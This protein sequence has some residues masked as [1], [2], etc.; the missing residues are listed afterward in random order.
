MTGSMNFGMASPYIETF[1]IAQAAAAKIYSVIDNIP[2]I[3]QSKGKGEKPG[4]I[5]GNIVFQDVHFQY[6]S[7][8][9]VQVNAIGNFCILFNLCGIQ[10]LR[11]FN[12]TVKAGETVALVGS[13]G[14]GKSTV[15]QLIQRFYDPVS[16][17]V[18]NEETNCMQISTLLLCCR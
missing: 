11:G 8:P 18:S 10:V 16:G 13:S 2:V 7:R 5:D 9:T 17:N 3:N 6:P 12:L 14:C 15:L 4:K 1:G